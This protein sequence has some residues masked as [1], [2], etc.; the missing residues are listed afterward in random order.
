MQWPNTQGWIIHKEK[1]FLSISSED[2][3][4]QNQ[5]TSRLLSGRTAVL[6]DDTLLL[7]PAER[8]NAVCSHGGRD[9]RAK[10]VNSLCQALL[11]QGPLIP[12][13]KAESHNSKTSS[14]PHLLKTQLH[15][16]LNF[17]INFGDG[18][19]KTFK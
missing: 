14:R 2:W 5:G 4:A 8:R 10:G 7:H 11:L 6:H 3:K 12:F 19:T 15:W 17:N 9:G 1:R 16:G 18:R 13:M